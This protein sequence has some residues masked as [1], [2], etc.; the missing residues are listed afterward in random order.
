AAWAA[1]DLSPALLRSTRKAAAELDA[2]SWS[3]ATLD[4]RLLAARIATG[5]G[6]L[7]VA[8]N[9]LRLAAKAR[10]SAQLERRARAWHAL[11]LLRMQAGDR[12]GA[13]AAVSA[14]LTAAER[15]RALLG[16]TELRVMVASH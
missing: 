5:L 9:E 3:T 15:V 2:V 8:R 16:A 7:E 6:H 4:L 1:G 10:H 13:Y 12:R 11:A 14:G